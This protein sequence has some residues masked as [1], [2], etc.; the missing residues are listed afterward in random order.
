MSIRRI[1]DLKPKLLEACTK[2]GWQVRNSRHLLLCERGDNTCVIDGK[3]SSGPV[4]ERELA[5][6]M[7]EIPSSSQIILITMG[8]FAPDAYKAILKDENRRNKLILIS[9][10][11]RDYMD[12]EF[13]PT[14]LQLAKPSDLFLEIKRI[15]KDCGLQLSPANCA[16]CSHKAIAICEFCGKLL[17]KSHLVPC[18]LCQIILC[19]PDT[20]SNCLFDHRCGS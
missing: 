4:H 1:S 8:F 18:P 19:H 16:I 6:W 15:L 12:T 11:L 3:E 10:G 20:A 13:K 7:S 9:L 17:C 2:L 5:L 14:V